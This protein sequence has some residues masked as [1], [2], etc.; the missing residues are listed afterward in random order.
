MTRHESS[1]AIDNDSDLDSSTFTLQC[2]C[3]WKHAVLRE[4]DRYA[5]YVFPVTL[6]QLWAIWMKHLGG[7]DD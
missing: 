7:S 5:G 3:G 1:I 6:E 4:Y 2:T